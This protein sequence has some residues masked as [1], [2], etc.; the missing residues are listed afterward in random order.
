MIADFFLNK[1]DDDSFIIKPF[2]FSRRQIRN[3]F[4]SEK[5]GYLISYRDI[6][7]NEISLL[8][9]GAFTKLRSLKYL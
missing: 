3:V 7:S 9:D 5:A 4:V 6:S 8:P 1:D 2:S